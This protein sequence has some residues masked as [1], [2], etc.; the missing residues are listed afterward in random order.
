MGATNL[1]NHEGKYEPHNGYGW[2]Q[3]IFLKL[4][5]TKTPEINDKNIQLVCKNGIS[6]RK[7]CHVNNVNGKRVRT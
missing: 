7:M 1:Q 2:H 4:K 5:T 3:N 6:I